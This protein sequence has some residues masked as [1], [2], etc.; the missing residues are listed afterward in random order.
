MAALVRR[1]N[2]DGSWTHQVKVKDPD[3][4]WYPTPGFKNLDDAMREEARLVELKRKGARAISDDAKNV[5]LDEYWE[6]WSRENRSDVSEG[7]K[8]SQNQM[9]R[10]YIK[11]ILGEIKM[12]LIK[13]PEIGRALNRA[14]EMGLGDQT[15]KHI[16]SLLRKMF[17]D[18][19]E[20]YEMLAISPVKPKFHRPKVSE[21][22]R[23]FLH[24]KQAWRL[25]EFSRGHYLSTAIWLQVLSGLRPSEVQALRGKSLLFDL[26]QILICAAF[27]NKTGELQDY[28]KQEDWGY[29]PM[30]PQLKEYLLELKVKADDFV[31]KGPQGGMLSYN[32]YHTALKKLCKD[33]G[34]LAVT[35]H[36]LRHTCTE[37]YMQ[38]G[39]SAEDIRRLLNH[40]SL[41]ATKHYIHRTDERLNSIAGNLQSTNF[42]RSF[43]NGKKE[44]VSNIIGEVESVH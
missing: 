16:Y 24:P 12:I 40:H 38:A 5:T 7:W 13:P 33:A 42:P 28:P 39:A 4:K 8:I 1:K 31:A 32:T 18:A 35:P 41:T 3:G 43:P 25:L 17:N 10:D 20:Y 44:A 15:R 21:K 37:I 22:K 11:P 23:N 34:V 36:E 26:N 30:P 19:V 6:V 29:S 9:Y 14:Q 2:R 27:N